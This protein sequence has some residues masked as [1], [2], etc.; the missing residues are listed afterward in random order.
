MEIIRFIQFQESLKT[1]YIV[2]NVK[3]GND[4]IPCPLD[5]DD[6]QDDPNAAI[7]YATV[8]HYWEAMDVDGVDPPEFSP[9]TTDDIDTLMMQVIH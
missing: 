1:K 2:V 7:F 5:F 9:P 4:V 6:D 8:D 3:Y